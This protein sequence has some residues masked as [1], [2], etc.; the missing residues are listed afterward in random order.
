[1]PSGVAKT[2]R[3]RGSEKALRKMS[4]PARTDSPAEVFDDP[5]FSP[6]ARPTRLAAAPFRPPTEQNVATCSQE[7]DGDMSAEVGAVDEMLDTVLGPEAELSPETKTS[8]R[9]PHVESP[10]PD[11]ARRHLT[12]YGE[13]ERDEAVVLDDKQRRSAMFRG[14][15]VP[16]V[17]LTQASWASTTLAPPIIHAPITHAGRAL[18]VVSLRTGW[19]RTSAHSSAALDSL[20][21]PVQALAQHSLSAKR[22]A[23]PGPKR[24]SKANARSKACRSLRTPC[25]TTHP[26][27]PVCA[28]PRQPVPRGSPQHQDA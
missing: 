5:G 22:G 12:L 26:T 25:F 27:L 4:N 23:K 19:A 7:G 9:P 2:P 13:W 17:G 18:G 14:G 3:P 11:T 16:V 10:P 20:L 24:G 6:K 8:P 15:A 1:M 28:E 21:L